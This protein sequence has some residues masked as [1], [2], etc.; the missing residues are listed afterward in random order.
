[1]APFMPTFMDLLEGIKG[2]NDLQKVKKECCEY[3]QYTN[4]S[5]RDSDNST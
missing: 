5:K 2:E 3:I 1:M 4:F